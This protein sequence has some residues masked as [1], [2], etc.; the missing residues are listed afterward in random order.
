VT[1]RNH[2]TRDRESWPSSVFVAAPVA[3]A[4]HVNVTATVDV[5]KN[6]QPFDHGHGSGH[7]D[8]HGNAHGCGHVDVDVLV[9]VSGYVDDDVLSF[10]PEL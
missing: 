6:L 3:V 4:V 10:L 2:Q 1:G 5:I 9:N 8:V 7:V